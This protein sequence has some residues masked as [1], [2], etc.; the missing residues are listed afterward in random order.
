MGIRGVMKIPIH[1][2]VV[3]ECDPTADAQTTVGASH[4]PQ[5]LSHSG[6]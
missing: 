4:Y 2:E 1:A 3:V 6:V 5:Q